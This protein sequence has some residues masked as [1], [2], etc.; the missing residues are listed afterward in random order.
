[1]LPPRAPKLHGMV[2]RLNR[3]F[4][5]EFWNS[6]DDEGELETVQFH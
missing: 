3:A 4:R 6:Y 1:M 2:E 5:E